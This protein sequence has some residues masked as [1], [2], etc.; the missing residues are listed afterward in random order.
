MN[1]VQHTGAQAGLLGEHEIGDLLKKAPEWY[2]AE[3]F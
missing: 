2:K 3:P 1:V